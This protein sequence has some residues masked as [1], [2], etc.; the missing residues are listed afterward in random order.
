M[1]VLFGVDFISM[2]LVVLTNL[3]IYLC[4]LSL[5]AS[6]IYGKYMLYEII[7]LLFFIQ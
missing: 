1:N 6:D 3:F 4:I 2:S 5:R 7:I